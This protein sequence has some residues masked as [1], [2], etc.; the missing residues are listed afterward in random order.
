[1]NLR[2][3]V[4]TFTYR[5]SMRNPQTGQS[6]SLDA[7]VDTGATFTTIPE[8]VLR[9]L[10]I[11]PVRTVEMELADGTVVPTPLGYAEIVVDGEAMLGTC[12]FG[13]PESPVLL[14]AAT[15]E[16]LLLAPDAVNERFIQGR[17]LRT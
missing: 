7:L 13:E 8:P 3:V 6:V 15:M 2:S 16:S 10:G 1:M 9:Q 14:G 11:Q 17:A 12:V 5:I 4:G